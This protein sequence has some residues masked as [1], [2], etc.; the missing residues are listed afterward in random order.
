MINTSPSVA[1]LDAATDLLSI[2]E[3]AKDA[4]ALKAT[5][6]DV[7]AEALAA[8]AQIEELAKA[9]SDLDAAWAKAE[10]A[11]AAAQ[12]KIDKADA[13]IANVAKGFADLEGARSAMK[14]DRSTQDQWAAQVREELANK[15]AK[16]ASDQ[17]QLDKRD[18]FL[19][20][21][22]AKLDAEFATAVNAQQ[23]A[24]A[25]GADYEAKM[26]ALRAVTA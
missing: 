24:L 10:K 6:A 13:D 17:D 22:E 2:L 11:E 3:L 4:S 8:A 1:A 19:S 12:V 16:I 18:L 9:Q 21:R 23:A 5:I 15:Q 26:A 25:K 7:R 20:D 14:I